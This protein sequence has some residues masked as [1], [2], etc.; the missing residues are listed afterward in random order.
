MVQAMF[1][2]L[3][4]T[5]MLDLWAQFLNFSFKL[6]PTNWGLV[7]RWFA[8]MPKGQFIHKP[9]SKAAVMPYEKLIGWSAHYIIGFA[10]AWLYMLLVSYSTARSPSLLTAAGFG[11][12]TVMAPWFILQPGMGMGLFARHA[13]DPWLKRLTSLLAHTVFG[14]GLYLGWWLFNALNGNQF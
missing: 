13:P 10:Y 12:A 14:I 5:L 8:H 6:M 3:V 1:I 11:I 4:A 7:G 9:I 2:G